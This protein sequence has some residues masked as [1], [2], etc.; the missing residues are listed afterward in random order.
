M[1]AAF[2]AAAALAAILLAA[3]GADERGTHIALRA[4]ARLSFLLFLPAYLGGA[5]VALF[6]SGFRLL[7]QQGREFGLAFA[8]AHLVHIGLVLWLCWIGAAPAAGVFLFFGVALIWT[9]LIALF[10]I[11]RL[12]Q[13][14]GR[15]SLWLLRAV[16]MNYIAY[17]FA[18]DFVRFPPHAGMAHYAEY[19][20]FSV[21][22][23][24]GPV[25]YFA[26]LALSIGRM[27]KVPS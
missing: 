21:M 25:V 4:S 8:S 5:L 11:D 7:K 12:Q 17:A 9:Y 26:A 22:S 16:G 23:V 13:M 27:R 18:V 14:I 15:R 1:S 19:A 6:G 20:P 2:C 24:A 3:F 10:S